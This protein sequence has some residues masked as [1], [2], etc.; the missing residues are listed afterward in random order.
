MFTGEVIVHR[1]VLLRGSTMVSW[2]S[3]AGVGP[4]AGMVVPVDAGD[5]CDAVQVED[6]ISLVRRGHKLKV[7]PRLEGGV[8]IV[9]GLRAVDGEVRV[10][11]GVDHED[12]A[13]RGDLRRHRSGGWRSGRSGLRCRNGLRGEGGLV[14][15]ECD[16]QEGDEDADCVAANSIHGVAS[17]W[18]R[19]DVPAN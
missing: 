15:G 10:C 17:V 16:T 4:D 12:A 7:T 2:E 19:A 6:E 3:G 5:G 13:R 18:R 1:G 9:V 14:E 8:D 11:A